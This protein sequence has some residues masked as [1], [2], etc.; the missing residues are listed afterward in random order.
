MLDR[1][2]EQLS[3]EL[4]FENSLEPVLPGVFILPLE[5]DV[6]VKLTT[7]QQGYSLE[8]NIASFPQF[9]KEKFASQAL[10]ANL[11]GQGTRG[12]VIG[13]AEEGNM[14]T[15]SKVVDYNSDY[16]DFKENLEDFVTT[17]AFW[18]NETRIH[19]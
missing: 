16:K 17:I 3:K 8:A 13:L 19:K 9:N 14:L 5:D 1:F 18:K 15:L 7:L 11:F 10:L 12:A 2:I 4:Q 6:N